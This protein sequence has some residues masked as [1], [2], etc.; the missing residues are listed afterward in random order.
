[1]SEIIAKVLTVDPSKVTN[2]RHRAE[3]ERTQEWHRIN[4]RSLP[5]PSD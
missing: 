5:D 3:L 1:M 4:P 2:E